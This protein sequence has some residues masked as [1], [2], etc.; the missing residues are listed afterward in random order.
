VS[1]PPEEAWPVG[2]VSPAGACDPMKLWLGE[3][4]GTNQVELQLSRAFAGPGFVVGFSRRWLVTFVLCK[5]WG[6]VPAP[7]P[8][9]SIVKRTVGARWG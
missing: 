3:V 6:I 7:G 2:D 8:A 9:C 4:L 1:R 5:C